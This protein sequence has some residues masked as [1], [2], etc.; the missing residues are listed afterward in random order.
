VATQADLKDEKA[1]SA[2]HGRERDD[3]L[4]VSRGGSVLQKVVHAAKRLVIGAAVGA[5]AAKVAR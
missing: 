2:T 4:R 5:V 1:K 3:A